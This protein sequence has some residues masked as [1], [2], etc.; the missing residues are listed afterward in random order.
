MHIEN[1]R[2][3]LEDMEYVAAEFHPVVPGEGSYADVCFYI[4]TEN[5]HE[6]I[7]VAYERTKEDPTLH[8]T[9]MYVLQGAFYDLVESILTASLQCNQFKYLRVFEGNRLFKSK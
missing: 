1:F 3:M 8:F 9:R 6:V 5:R 4:A 7:S 2:R